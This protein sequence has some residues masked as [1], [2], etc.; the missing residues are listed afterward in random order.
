MA[1]M[2]SIAPA[3]TTTTTTTKGKKKREEKLGH[4]G[5][6]KENNLAGRFKNRGKR[7]SGS[8][9][10]TDL[11]RKLRRKTERTQTHTRTH[12]RRAVIFKAYDAIQFLRVSLSSSLHSF[13]YWHAC[14]RVAQIKLWFKRTRQRESDDGRN[15]PCIRHSV[16]AGQMPT[17]T[18]R[19]MI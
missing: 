4:E 18:K 15:S 13:Y 3:T 8:F 2:R 10:L 16:F 14:E 11:R 6:G 19:G 9:R 12:H 7:N 1:M 5:I 17:K